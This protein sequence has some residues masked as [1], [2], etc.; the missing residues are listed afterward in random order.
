MAY[1][2]AEF[3]STIN[4]AQWARPDAPNPRLAAPINSTT[5]T[6]LFTS[7]PLDRLGAV[8]DGN[9][10]FNIRNSS[11]YTELCY[12]PTGDMSA[13]GLTASNVVRGVRISGLDYTTGDS[14]YA[15]DHEAD[16][17][18]GFAV[19]AIYESILRDVILGILGTGGQL[20]VLGDGTDQDYTLSYLD[21]SGVQGLL[22]INSATAKA[23]YS[24]DGTTWVNIDTAAPANVTTRT[25][26]PAAAN[27]GE[28]FMNS[29]D[30]NSLWFK[31]HGGTSIKLVDDATQKIPLSSLQLYYG[32]SAT[33]TDAYSVTYAPVPAAL[34]DGQSYYVKTDVANTG[35][36]TFNANTAAAE[37]ALAIK[38]FNDQDT[39]TG[40]I[41]AGMTLHLVYSSAAGNFKMMNPVATQMSTANSATLTAGAASNADG[42]HTHTNL[43]TAITHGVSSKDLTDAS[44]NQV[45]AHGLGATPK[46]IE[47]ESFGGRTGVSMPSS[48]YGLYNGSTYSTIYDATNTGGSTGTTSSSTAFVVIVYESNNNTEYQTATVTLDATNITLAWTRVN[49]PTG[50]A[51]FKW[52]AVR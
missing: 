9:F 20:F 39:E 17:P 16:S 27:N 21:S 25:T 12:V 44:G 29:D 15:A 45:I 3:L 37:G 7:A 1:T 28:L 11:G 46:Y 5:T 4:F 30:S 52:K 26:T 50:T 31:D 14:A 2:P 8:I 33:G 13:D 47:I 23:Q 43:V 36:C 41:E 42:L 51:I 10:L 18:V 24:N 48:S 34:V 6:I 49:A 32:A 40:D 38:K 19:N 22:R 35:A